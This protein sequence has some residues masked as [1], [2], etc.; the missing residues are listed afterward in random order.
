MHPG[1]A[2][3]LAYAVVGGASALNLALAWYR[4]KKILKETQHEPWP[5]DKESVEM[6]QEIR[7]WL[8]AYRQDH[9]GDYVNALLAGK[10]PYCGDR[11][12][13]SKFYG[14][15]DQY[16]DHW[17]NECGFHSELEVLV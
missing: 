4:G 8:H 5:E 10:C 11:H 1:L 17:C 13:E 2:R 16:S 9:W 14:S 3:L 12:L 15:V 7:D 6:N